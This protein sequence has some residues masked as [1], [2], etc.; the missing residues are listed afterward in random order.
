[1]KKLQI[2]IF[3]IFTILTNCVYAYQL[4]VYQGK[5]FVIIN[6][7]IPLINIDDANKG[8]FEIYSPLDHLGRCGTAYANISKE[9]MPTGKRGRIGMIKPSGWKTKRYDNIVPGKY[10]YNH[11]HLIGYQLAGENANVLNLITGTRYLNMNMLIFENK[12]V[13]YVHKTGNHVL[14]RVTP[15]FINNELVARGIFIEALSVEDNGQGICFFIYCF[16][17]QP[18]ININYSDGTSSIQ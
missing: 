5:P 14:Y 8:N 4:P 11:C 3:L 7:N 2:L 6:N 13:K 16:N 9:L 1:M 17:V 15:V 18:H 10:L 12:V